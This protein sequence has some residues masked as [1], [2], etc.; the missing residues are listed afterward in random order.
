MQS[1][2]FQKL[3]ELS[4]YEEFSKSEATISTLS[5]SMSLNSST[6]GNSNKAVR[7]SFLPYARK[8]FKKMMGSKH[9]AKHEVDNEQLLT[10]H[11]LNVKKNDLTRFEEAQEIRNT[12]L[13]TI[14]Y[15]ALNFIEDDIQLSDLRRYILEGRITLQHIQ[16]FFPENALEECMKICT[17]INYRHAMHSNMFIE[18]RMITNVHHICTQLRIPDLKLPNISRLCQR[19]ITELALPKDLMKYIERLINIYKPEMRWTK[20]Y[21]PVY[22]ARAIA[23]IIFILKLLFGLDD[24]MEH[25]ISESS[26]KINKTIS[27]ANLF[28]FDDWMRYLEMRKVI[29]SQAYMPFSVVYK[30]ECD[31]HRRYEFLKKEFT[32]D[33]P[34]FRKPQVDNLDRIIESFLSNF[35]HEEPEEFD[36]SLPTLT[37]N[38]TYF[39]TVLNS[40]KKLIIPDFMHKN[41]S[42]SSIAAF[43]NQKNLKNLAKD[44]M[45]KLKVEELELREHVKIERFNRFKSLFQ[46]RYKH[47][48]RVRSA[49]FEID[50]DT[51][52]KQVKEEM[53]NESLVF[54][55]EVTRKTFKKSTVEIHRKEDRTRA[56]AGPTKDPV[57]VKQENLFDCLSEDEEDI[58]EGEE[59]F[60]ELVFKM[61]N[62]DYWT[63]MGSLN[64]LTKSEINVVKGKLPLNLKWLVTYCANMLDSNWETIYNELLTIEAN[65]MYVLEPMDSVTNMVTFQER[66][67]ADVV[68]AL[69]LAW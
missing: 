45:Y 30:T 39:Q 10:C 28:V 25:E 32:E 55:N 38:A 36:F 61:S 2:Y 66:C 24:S 47:T 48:V 50:H 4:E 58:Y 31:S 33:K 67:D 21:T 68:N 60:E 44:H 29:L 43:I 26:R 1:I 17:S 16:K 34:Y 20:R 8:R 22:E 5:N 15:I 19:Y 56:P 64:S 65:F 35:H 49:D 9:L 13:Y 57:E 14:L 27:D 63:V 53:E 18:A 59:N 52:K 23:Y 69:R 37:P 62:M 54:G 41:P 3:L 11:N 40:S 12:T 51:W 42:E 46:K 7:L 6:S